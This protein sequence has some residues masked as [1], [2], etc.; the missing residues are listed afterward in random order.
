MTVYDNVEKYGT[1]GRATDNIIRHM[2]IS[3]WIIEATNAHPESVIIMII[4]HN[5]INC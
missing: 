1:T 2:H 4:S 3:C 5:A